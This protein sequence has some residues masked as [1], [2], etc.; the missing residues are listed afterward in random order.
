MDRA[1]VSTKDRETQQDVANVLVRYATGIDSKDWKLFRTCFTEDCQAD[2]G[3]Q[4]GV[5]DGVEAIADYMERTHPAAV[6]T[7]HRITNA[8]VTPNGDRAVARSYVDVIFV[9]EAT[10]GGA[11][12]AGFYDDELVRTD[13]GWKIASRRYT[14]VHMAPIEGSS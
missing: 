6:R 4:I 12:A 8:T 3:E 11:H 5:W 9:V 1:K 10:G 13:K 2:Y 14:M 7:L